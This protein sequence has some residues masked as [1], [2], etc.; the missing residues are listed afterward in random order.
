MALPEQWRSQSTHTHAAH[1]RTLKDDCTRARQV[2]GLR[3]SDG[4]EALLAPAMLPR[5][6]LQHQ[7]MLAIKDFKLRFPFA[8][9]GQVGGQLLHPTTHIVWEHA[10]IQPNNRAHART[11]T[12][13]RLQVASGMGGDNSPIAGGGNY[14]LTYL[15]DNT[16]IGRAT[17]LG[18]SFIFSRAE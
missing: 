3:I 2:G 10:F 18:G 1:A 5:T 13:V 11:H 15:D 7:L 12:H 6:S 14:Q 16:L 9:V 17:A 8:S 4:L